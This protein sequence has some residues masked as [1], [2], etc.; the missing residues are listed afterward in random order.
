MNRCIMTVVSEPFVYG[1]IATFKSFLHHHPDFSDPIV[2]LWSPLNASLSPRAKEM[3][4]REIPIIEFKQV[5]DWHYEPI[6]DF[7]ENVVNTPRRLRAAFYILEAFRSDYDHIVTLD[8]DM[9]VLDRLDPLFECEAPFAAV[10]AWDYDRDEPLSYFNT[11]TMVIRRDQPGSLTFEDILDAIA[12]VSE[13]DDSHGKADQA[14]LNVALRDVPLHYLS[15]RF[16]FSKRALDTESLNPIEQL[17][18]QDVR[19]LH[20]LGEK[21]WN[22]KIKRRETYYN[23]IEKIWWSEVFRL[24]DRDTLAEL[25]NYHLNAAY[26]AKQIAMKPQFQAKLTITR[27]RQMESEFVD[28]IWE[29]SV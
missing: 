29:N 1:A 22:P 19:I 4:V 27:Q 6:F 23:E 11:G 7:A 9:L 5:N 18:E 28:A 26:I 21:P 14:V 17:R 25:Q 24:F 12:P 3:M 15:P 13:V 8:S 20:Y 16:N 10:R 2:V